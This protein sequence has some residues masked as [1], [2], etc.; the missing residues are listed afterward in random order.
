MDQHNKTQLSTNIVSQ[1]EKAPQEEE[2]KAPLINSSQ[3]LGTPSQG[4][5]ERS[6]SVFDDD[7]PLSPEYHLS[8]HVGF[9]EPTEKGPGNFSNIFG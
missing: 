1:R 5:V 3:L 2:E 9:G 6:V 7:I 8:N 4:M